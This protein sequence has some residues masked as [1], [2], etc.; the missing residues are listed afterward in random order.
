[1]SIAIL[2]FACA[3]RLPPRI[4]LYSGNALL[5]LPR[6]VALYLAVAAFIHRDDDLFIVRA[7]NQCTQTPRVPLDL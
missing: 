5:R 6:Y 3:H 1:M 7:G 2:L 4:L